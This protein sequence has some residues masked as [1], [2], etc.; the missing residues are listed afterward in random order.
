MHSM[1]QNFKLRSTYPIYHTVIFYRDARDILC[2][3]FNVLTH[4]EIIFAFC[5]LPFNVN[6]YFKENIREHTCYSNNALHTCMTMDG[7][8]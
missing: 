7:W 6:N 3:F 4:K 2:K 5:I 8:M 1:F